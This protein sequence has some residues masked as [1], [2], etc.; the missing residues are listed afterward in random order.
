MKLAQLDRHPE[1]GQGLGPIGRALQ[2]LDTLTKAHS[3][4]W[5]P[6][7]LA[8]A[9]C[10]L[11]DAH[12]LMLTDVATLAGRAS[13]ARDEGSPLAMSLVPLPGVDL[14]NVA[15]AVAAVVPPGTDVRLTLGDEA[16]PQPGPGTTRGQYRAYVADNARRL[17]A[18]DRAGEV[19]S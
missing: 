4:K 19:Q 7:Q 16:H 2:W 10:A 9:K 17:E 3:V 13:V 15:E 11:N 18:M 8:A 5:D 1:Y 12:E 14:R 6:K